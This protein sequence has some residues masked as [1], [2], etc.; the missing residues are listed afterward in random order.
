MAT[1]PNNN[2][3]TEPA[4]QTTTAGNKRRRQEGGYVPIS[5]DSLPTT[6][7]DVLLIG[8]KRDTQIL[9]TA[10]L[11]VVTHPGGT[12]VAALAPQHVHEK[13]ELSSNDNTFDM[14]AIDA[15]QRTLQDEKPF[16]IWSRRHVHLLETLRHRNENPAL[17]CMDHIV[18]VVPTLFSP[19]LYET[20]LTNQAVRKELESISDRDCL[21]QKVTIVAL[22]DASR[23]DDSHHETTV[24][25]VDTDIEM[26]TTTTTSSSIDNKA[27]DAA[28]DVPIIVCH[29]GNKASVYA[30]ARQLWKRT[31]IGARTDANSTA[32]PLLFSLQAK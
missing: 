27:H 10:L 24:P 16:A 29:V 13:G 25:N 7:K 19:D 23:R 2:H 20:V 21:L 31:A 30:T 14:L 18:L 12:S 28:H 3:P 1:L 6:G 11:Q 4:M 17:P 22:V 9:A 15:L 5:S 32:S 8:E 26:D